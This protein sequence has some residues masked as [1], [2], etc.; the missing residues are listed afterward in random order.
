MK[1]IPSIVGKRSRQTRRATICQI[2]I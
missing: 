2:G 1:I